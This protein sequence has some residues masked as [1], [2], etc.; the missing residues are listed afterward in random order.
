MTPRR[1]A[2]VADIEENCGTSAHVLSRK[3]ND[4]RLQAAG[5][6]VWQG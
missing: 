4:Y 5:A 1:S 2:Q 6:A 3:T